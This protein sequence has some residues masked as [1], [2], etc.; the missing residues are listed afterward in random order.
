MNRATIS[1]KWSQQFP[2]HECL[3]RRG[4][5]GEMVIALILDACWGK[6]T[7][8]SYIMWSL[9]SK[10][11]IFCNFIFE[12]P[13]RDILFLEWRFWM[14][15]EDM[16]S[17][18]SWSLA[19][20]QLPLC[21]INHWRKSKPQRES[22]RWELV[23]VHVSPYTLAVAILACKS[24]WGELPHFLGMHA[25]KSTTQHYIKLSQQ[26]SFL[27]STME[28]IL[29]TWLSGEPCLAVK[30]FIQPHLLPLKKTWL[31]CLNKCG[32]YW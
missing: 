4:E 17:T 11:E 32:F 13:L 21:P 1:S 10:G 6:S 15:T 20:P 7:P 30:Q 5:Q 22:I 25:S 28:W 31:T 26:Q 3:E 9:P 27:L 14:A 24:W 29:N 23:V 18:F 19:T 2:V 12:H 8:N 16:G